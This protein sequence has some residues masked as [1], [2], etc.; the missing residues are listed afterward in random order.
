MVVVVDFVVA[1]VLVVMD[2]VVD[3]ISVVAESKVVFKVLV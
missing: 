2:L 3:V 1:V